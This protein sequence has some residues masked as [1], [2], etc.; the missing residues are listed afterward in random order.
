[1]NYDI[2]FRFKDFMKANYPDHK[3]EFGDYHLRKFEE[4]LENPMLSK[5]DFKFLEC[6]ELPDCCFLIISKD[7]NNYIEIEISGE[8][9]FA[10]FKCKETMFKE[11][12]PGRTYDLN[13]LIDNFKMN[14]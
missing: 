14:C 5:D 9:C 4:Y 6:F 1:M 13:K 8:E 12:Q 10:E 3:I 2:I 11:L 7:R